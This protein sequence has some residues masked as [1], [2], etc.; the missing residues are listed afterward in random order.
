M[1]VG[2]RILRTAGKY[3]FP[4]GQQME[5][6]FKKGSP[7]SLSVPNAAVES[8]EVFRQPIETPKPLAVGTRI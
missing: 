8:G 2:L 7:G 4:D 6:R 1:C 3:A 5:C